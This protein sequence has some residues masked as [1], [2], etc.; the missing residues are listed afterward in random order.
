MAA[1]VFGA[2]DVAG[3]GADWEPIDSTGNLAATNATAEGGNGDDIAE[4][5]HNTIHSGTARYHYTGAEV[6][7]VAALV[8]ADALPG[9]LVATDTLMVM[10][11]AIDYSPCARGELPIVTL[12]LQ[13]GPTADPATPFWYTTD[14][15]LPTYVAANII[16][17]QAILAATLGDAEVVN[18]QWSLEMQHGRSL[19]KDGE[20]LAGQGY[21]GRENLTLTTKGVPTSI[22]STGWSQTA[23]PS[24]KLATRQNQG[25]T[26]QTY[27]FTRLKARATA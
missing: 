16:V 25:Y 27:T 7:F 18:A 12:T 14:L 8:A 2:T 11:V 4:T 19:D 23:G 17:P 24:T 21:A 20:Y 22:T 13:D 3:L 26:D 6:G 15:T 5:A 1:P 10:G 9:Q